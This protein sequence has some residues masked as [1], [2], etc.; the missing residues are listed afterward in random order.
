MEVATFPIVGD[1]E[2]LA[3]V[4]V[5]AVTVQVDFKFPVMRLVGNRMGSKPRLSGHFGLRVKFCPFH[6][7]TT[8]MEHF[9]FDC[10]VVLMMLG[11]AVNVTREVALSSRRKE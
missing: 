3:K 4:P 9:K 6:P 11:Y 1:S 5:N 7:R 10:Y 8:L 2:S